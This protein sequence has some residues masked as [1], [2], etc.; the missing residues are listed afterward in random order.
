MNGLIACVNIVLL[1]NYTDIPFPVEEWL[2]VSYFHRV[3]KVL[4]Q[5]IELPRVPQS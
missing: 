5:R 1:W 4:W 2:H 3:N